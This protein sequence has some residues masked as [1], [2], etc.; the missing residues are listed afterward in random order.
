MPDPDVLREFDVSVTLSMTSV[1]YIHTHRFLQEILAFAQNFNQL[2][3]V[4]GRSRA[5]TIGKKVGTCDINE[6]K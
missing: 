1:W 2:Q 4:L 5:S 6:E 3:D